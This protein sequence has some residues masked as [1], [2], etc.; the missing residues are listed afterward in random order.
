MGN[1]TPGVWKKL[2][3]GGKTFCDGL[4]T[5]QGTVGQPG[6]PRGGNAYPIGP[7]APGALVPM[8]MMPL[9]GEHAHQQNGWTAAAAWVDEL[10][11]TWKTWPW[12][13]W[14]A[15]RKLVGEG[16][17]AV[18]GLLCA[19]VTELVNDDCTWWGAKC[20]MC[21]RAANVRPV[22]DECCV[23][24][25]WLCD[26]KWCMCVDVVGVCAMQLRCPKC[27]LMI[28]LSR[29]TNGDDVC[30]WNV[31]VLCDDDAQ[32][33]ACVAMTSAAMC[34]AK[35]W[36]DGH[37][38]DVTMHVWQWWSWWVSDVMWCD[39]VW[40]EMRVCEMCVVMWMCGE[41]VWESESE[42]CCLWIE[43]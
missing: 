26:I 42:M 40:R 43:K 27:L 20:G 12:P 37:V 3:T 13:W 15:G 19:D 16:A 1:P 14:R 32:C 9:L 7:G 36:C 24:W 18:A 28:V 5:K 39:A 10:V 29:M 41:M 33:C 22:H 31:C 23:M 4:G 6:A 30:M 21:E 35:D 34:A 11:K 8:T 38:W 2:P 17:D 25:A